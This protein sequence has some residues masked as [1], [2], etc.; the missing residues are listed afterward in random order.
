MTSGGNNF[1]DLPETTSTGHGIKINK[2][3]I[4]LDDLSEWVDF[5]PPSLNLKVCSADDS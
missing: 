3:S 4:H 2:R 5:R 1:N